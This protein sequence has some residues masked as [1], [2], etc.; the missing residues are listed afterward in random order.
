MFFASEVFEQDQ[1]TPESVCRYLGLPR[2]EYAKA[3]VEWHSELSKIKR[4]ETNVSERDVL[5]LLESAPL[6]TSM[7]S[8]KLVGTSSN[9]S[10]LHLLNSMADLG[11]ISSRTAG[12]RKIWHISRPRMIIVPGRVS[13]H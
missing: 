11:K 8:R 7:I 3:M 4:S 13:V 10:V 2:F 9:R 6:E 5:E 12:S 1:V